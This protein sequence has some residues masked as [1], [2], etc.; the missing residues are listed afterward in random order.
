MYPH[1]AFE[2][3]GTLATAGWVSMLLAL[4]LPRLRQ[5]VDRLTQCFVPALLGVAYVV[6]LLQGWNK[7]P[8]VGFGSIEQVRTFFSNDALLAAGWLHYLAFDLFVGNWIMTDGILRGIPR[9]VIALCLGLTF[10]FGPAR[11]LLFLSLRLIH[12]SK[13][14]GHSAAVK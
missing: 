8:G 6:L 13:R 9:L 14:S 1:A 2:W 12:W 10:L 11:L 4:F 5:S 7:A 3:A